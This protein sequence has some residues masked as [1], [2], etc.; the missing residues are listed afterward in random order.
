MGLGYIFFILIYL[1]S[2]IQVTIPLF[3]A[4]FGHMYELFDNGYLLL[5]P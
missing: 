3:V 2:L 5:E 4:Y 1:T